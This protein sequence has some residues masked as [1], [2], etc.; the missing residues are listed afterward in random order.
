MLPQSHHGRPGGIRH[1]FW[2]GLALLAGCSEPDSPETR[3][4]AVVTE[5]EDAAEERDVAAVLDHVSAGFRDDRGRGREELGQYLRGYFAMHPSVH[6]LTR[7]ESIEFPYRDY[8]R[9]RLTLGTLGRR[10]AGATSFDLAA[11]VHDVALELALEDGEWRVVRAA[12]ER[13]PAA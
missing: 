5:A 6:L 3:L 7:I 1:A 12:W 13:G 8:A 11:D 4:R 2:A 9:L 10:S